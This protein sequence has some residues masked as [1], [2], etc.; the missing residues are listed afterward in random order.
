MAAMTWNRMIELAYGG[1]P[2]E[3]C[4]FLLHSGA[5]GHHLPTHCCRDLA[6]LI[7]ANIAKRPRAK[8]SPETEASGRASKN[9]GVGIVLDRLR[10]KERRERK[11][12]RGKRRDAAID[13]EIGRLKP[14]YRIAPA[15]LRRYIK[16]AKSRRK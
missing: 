15:E 9:L 12:L 7:D 14:R 8:W 3:L 2:Q 6:K 4:D 16:S 11:Q 10:E 5:D 13:E 1:E